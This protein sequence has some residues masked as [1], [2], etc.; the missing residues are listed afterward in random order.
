MISKHFT[1]LILLMLLFASSL[2]AQLK[3]GQ[4]APEIFITEWIKNTPKS[5]DLSGKFVVIDF[6]ATWCAPCLESMPHM[7]NIIDKNKSRTNLVFLA[8]TDE[9]KPKVD[10]LLK[11]VPISAA[12][13]SDNTRKTLD[14][15]KIKNIPT[16]VVIDDNNE[17]KWIGHSAELTD[18]IIEKILSRE[19]P[20]SIKDDKP[21]TPEQVTKIADSVSKRYGTYFMDSEVKDYF[22]FGPLTVEKAVMNFYDGNR[23]MVIGSSLKEELAKYFQ[24][25]SN[26]IVLPAELAGKRISYLYKTKETRKDDNLRDLILQ[27]LNLKFA[28][29]DSLIEVMQ[30]EV[31]NKKLLNKFAAEPVASASHTSASKTYAAVSNAKFA[32]LKTEI[33]DA[34]NTI[35]VLKDQS[36]FSNKLSLT[37]R[38][39]NLDNLK[40][41]LLASGIEVS[42]V[43]KSLPVYRFQIV[44]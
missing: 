7:N 33:E 40:A 8:L 27:Q 12:V 36:K 39:D 31:V 19:D 11:R 23:I 25:S 44:R 3:V 38:I 42:T 37:I 30:L 16:C 41:S 1:V 24:V 14:A 18:E 10:W 17:I 29:A 28:L 15:F 20:N 4:K 2:H 22:N 5:K 43:K 6:W 34:F 35:V 26:Q 9:K 21:A 32:D 13:V